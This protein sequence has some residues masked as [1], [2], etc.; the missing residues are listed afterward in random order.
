VASI[1]E[2]GTITD[3][4]QI[5]ARLGAGAERWVE[6]KLFWSCQLRGDG[7]GSCGSDAN[8]VA[9]YC[10]GTP[11]GNVASQRDGRSIGRCA[12][13]QVSPDWTPAFAGEAKG[14][15]MRVTSN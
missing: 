14:L 8:G 9:R 15:W 1:G 3:M 7:V 4:D 10:A 6:N 12:Q 5:D 13:Q 11:I 2:G